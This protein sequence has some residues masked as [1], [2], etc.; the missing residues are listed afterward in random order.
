MK[1]VIAGL[2]LI[3]MAA[4]ALAQD[5]SRQ[6]LN[7]IAPAPPGGANDAL[8]RLLAI[9]LQETTGQTVVVLNKPG[10]NLVVGTMF[11][12]N[13]APDG[14]TLL[15]VG[16]SAV[17]V[18]PV[19]LQNLPYDAQKDLVPVS[20]VADLEMLFAVT[21][22]VPV[23]SVAEFVAYS[24]AHPKEINYAAGT[25]IFQLTMEMFKSLSG[26]QA[27]P[28]P[29]NGTARAITALLGG[30][31]QATI[32]EATSIM[33]HVQSG[34]LKALAAVPR[35]NALPNLPSL[36]Q[37]VPG[38]DMTV[39]LGLFAAKGTPAP[40]IARLHSEVARVVTST[41][42]SQKMI[43]MGM[44]P[45]GSSPEQLAKT[46]QQ[47]LANVRALAKTANIKID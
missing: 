32:S 35:V 22:A 23:N 27:T 41:D 18:N 31:V 16:N 1:N 36:A 28:I 2:L 17:T 45:V 9:K 11:V 34:K 7:I 42:A 46:I 38:Y 33:P 44:V 8:A 12:V 21:P 37:S 39:W 10:G 26:A 24:K 5:A 13:S 25:P 29:Y 30:E 47:D 6:P 19:L 15:L 20:K 40:T 43:G 3:G 14:R 4:P